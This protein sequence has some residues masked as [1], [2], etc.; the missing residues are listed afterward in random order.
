M[1]RRSHCVITA[2]IVVLCF[3]FVIL[4]TF[5]V[6]YVNDDR[7]CDDASVETDYRV[8]AETIGKVCAFCA[9]NLIIFYLNTRIRTYILFICNEKI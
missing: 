6:W 1:S 3:A 7:R 4:L 2:A 5:G 9:I 8:M